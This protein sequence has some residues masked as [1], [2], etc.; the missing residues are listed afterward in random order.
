MVSRPRSRSRVRFGEQTCL[1]SPRLLG[2]RR[3]AQQAGRTDP[4][5][6]RTACLSRVEVAF[7]AGQQLPAHAFPRLEEA[8]L[9]FGDF[10]AGEVG[11]GAPVGRLRRRRRLRRGGGIGRLR[12]MEK[13]A[14]PRQQ[15]GR[16]NR[17][18]QES[19]ATGFLGADLVFRPG[20]SGQAH[21]HA[22]LQAWVLLDPGCE[23]PAVHSGQHEIHEDQVGRQEAECRPSLFRGGSDIY[24]VTVLAQEGGRSL[25]GFG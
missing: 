2:D 15:Y 6:D 16:L 7:E 11:D 21:H 3:E 23:F 8:L 19:I 25:Q 13:F 4:L 22:S 17:L 20:G 18:G 5:V 9:Q 12:A 1:D 10:V 14:H 24:A